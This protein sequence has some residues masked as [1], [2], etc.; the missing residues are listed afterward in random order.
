MYQSI[1]AMQRVNYVRIYFVELSFTMDQW[2]LKSIFY[3]EISSSK[4]LWIAL[5]LLFGSPLIRMYSIS[6]VNAVNKAK[7]NI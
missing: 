7:E 1:L 4:I 5:I 6:F 3:E 2:W